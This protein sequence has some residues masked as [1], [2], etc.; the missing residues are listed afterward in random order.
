MPF[1]RCWRVQGASKHSVQFFNLVLVSRDPC[2]FVKEMLLITERLA[3][4][5]F[6]LVVGR[7]L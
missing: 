7:T 6:G 1:L 5:V 2:P 4:Y 3:L